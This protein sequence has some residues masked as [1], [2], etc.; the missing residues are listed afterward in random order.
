MT[1]HCFLDLPKVTQIVLEFG[2]QIPDWEGKFLFV[3]SLFI[4]NSP[5]EIIAY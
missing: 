4:F 5:Y 3:F 1:M 2:V